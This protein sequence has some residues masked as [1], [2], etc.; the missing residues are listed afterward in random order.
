M[1]KIRISI[2]PDVRFDF[3]GVIT[4]EQLQALIDQWK[5]LI[6]NNAALAAKF[7]EL[8]AGADQLKTS[9]QANS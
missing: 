5:A 9:V 2:A 6:P 4:L 1:F 8:Q 3:E 7:A